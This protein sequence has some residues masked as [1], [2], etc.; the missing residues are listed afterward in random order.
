MGFKLIGQIVLIIAS[1][2][3]VFSFIQPT[4]REIKATQNEV[5]QYAD[6]TANAAQFNARLNELIAIRDSFSAEDIAALEK[7]VPVSIDQLKVMRSI[8]SIFAN[9][10][11]RITSLVAK[12]EV[13]PAGDVSFES[14]TVAQEPVNYSNVSYQDFEVTFGGTYEQLREILHFTE[15]SDSLLE[16][17]SL[18]FDTSTE[19]DV[20]EDGAVA[21]RLTAD[22]YKFVIVFR[23]FG[24][25]ISSI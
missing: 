20:D 12:D 17:M 19:V 16:I 18:N 2:V 1:L 6:A 23:T 24:L 9:R 25:P 14:S 11:V 7:L 22:E 8:E 4:L 21:P 13:S 3:T 15:T 10:G 5:A